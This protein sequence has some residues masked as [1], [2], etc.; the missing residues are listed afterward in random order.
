MN[1]GTHCDGVR[2]YMGSDIK[3]DDIMDKP[4]SSKMGSKLIKAEE[5]LVYK[6]KER[7]ID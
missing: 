5:L 2:L 4:M 1:F 7:K 3:K 6:E